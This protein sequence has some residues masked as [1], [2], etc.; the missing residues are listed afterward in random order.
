[1]LILAVVWM[2]ILSP[3]TMSQPADTEPEPWTAAAGEGT[4]GPIPE[5]SVPTDH[6]PQNAAV[7]RSPLGIY[8]DACPSVY[9]DVEGLY[10]QR[11]PRLGQQPI[12]ED[13]DSHQTVIATSDLHFD[14]QPGLRVTAGFW[15]D[16]C[17]ALEISYMGL[18]ETGSSLS[19]AAGEG[20]LWKVPDP[21]GSAEDANVFKFT[22]RVRISYPSALNSFEINLPCCCCSTCCECDRVYCSSFEWFAG[23]RYINLT[24]DFNL[25]AERDEFGGTESGTYGI[26]AR[27]N[28]Y[29]AQLGARIRRGWDRFRWELT[30]KAGLYGNDAYQRQYITDFPPGFFLRPMV[31]AEHGQ[32]GFVGEINFA[33]VYKLNDVWGLRA[34][35]NVMWLEGV[36][37]APNQLDFTFTDTS[38]SGLNSC[39]GLFLHGG[40]L[41]LEGRW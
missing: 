19:A 8:C 33:L 5:L 16:D 18:F 32:V 17:R 14:F 29:G 3:R 11:V 36:A 24:E 31:S 21:L 4:I 30:G 12:I 28:L 1:M 34:G 41:G 13:F 27:N 20:S 22:D 2:A 15:L 7:D 23:F 10:M 39:G 37:L 26:H 35:Y 40:S 9:L 25:Y 38:G 6:S